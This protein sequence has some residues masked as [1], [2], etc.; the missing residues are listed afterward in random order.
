MVGEGIDN[1]KAAEN[2]WQI[3]QYTTSDEL[4]ARSAA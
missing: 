1:G 3:Q 4:Y 2:R